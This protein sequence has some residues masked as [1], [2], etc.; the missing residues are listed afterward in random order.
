MKNKLLL[1]GLF[2]VIGGVAIGIHY[3]IRIVIALACVGLAIF[4]LVSGLRMI[5]T[6]QAV[7]PTSDS[8]SAHRELHTGLSA[9]FW[10]MLFVIFSV[11]VGAFGISYW[12]YG[13]NPPQ[14]IVQGMMRSPLISGLVT[15]T[16]GVGLVLYGLT[17]V[18]PGKAAFVETQIGPFERGVTAVLNTA[19]GTVIAAAGVVRMLAPGALTRMRD[20]GIAWALELVK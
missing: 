3:H 13:D 8:A 1:L 19:L 14:E 6:R 4:S 15:V 2:L 18:L 17:R 5:R 11:P 10:G 20:A 9:Q 7:I 16:V 12:I